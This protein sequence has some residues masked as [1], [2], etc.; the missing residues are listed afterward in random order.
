[1]AETCVLRVRVAWAAKRC[2]CCCC[3]LGRLCGQLN[4]GVQLLLHCCV[5]LLQPAVFPLGREQLPASQHSCQ[6]VRWLAG[7]QRTHA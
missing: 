3:W 4:D 5:V 6:V 1:M 2:C 7:T